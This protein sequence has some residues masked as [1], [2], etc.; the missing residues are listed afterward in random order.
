[1]ALA[2][3]SGVSPRH[4]SFVETGRS[5][6]S[7]DLVLRLATVL[8]I[9]G[10]E[11]NVLL[12]RSGHSRHFPESRFDEPRLEHVRGVLRFIL[13]RH[14]PNGALVFD[15]HWQTLMCND[16]YRRIVSHFI[17]DP[18]L[19]DPVRQNVLLSTF[20]PG[21]IRPFVANWTVV[22][23]ALVAR[24]RRE[25]H[26]APSDLRLAELLDE[27]ESFGPIPT[28]TPLVEH[29]LLLPVHLRRGD[30][31]IRLFTVMTTIG[32]AVD[33][34]LQDLRIETFFPADKASQERLESLLE[35]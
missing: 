23:P 22:A 4:M 7:R 5:I 6:P 11:V 2:L 20:H 35:T 27:I 30:L 9:P 12:E 29:Q 24:V 1:M 19:P 10:R 32:S 13:D 26:A 16:G 21:G 8:D 25:V 14:E 31:D 17:A 33:I 34:A 18:S 28:A 15:R 3:E